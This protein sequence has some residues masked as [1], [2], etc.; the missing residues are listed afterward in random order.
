[1]KVVIRSLV[2]DDM[3]P[4][5]ALYHQFWGEES[6]TQAMRRTFSA[7]AQNEDYILLGAALDEVLVGSVMGVVCHELYGD[8]KPFLVLENMVVDQ[9]CRG[10]GIG[11]L[12]FA[13]LEQ[14]AAEKSCTQVILV[15]ETQRA[16]ACA[17]YESLGFHPTANRGYKKKIG[18]TT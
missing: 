1:M 16:E 2:I 17:F 8:C 14:Q 11:K 5:A 9:A 3:E 7:L 12:L 10:K 4:L 15:T 6:D 18:S 13:A